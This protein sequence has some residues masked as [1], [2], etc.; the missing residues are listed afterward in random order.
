METFYNIC[1]LYAKTA[2]PNI[3]PIIEWLDSFDVFPI[4]EIIP[5]IQD[6]I[7]SNFVTSKN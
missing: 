5:E 4:T 2:D 6:L 1:W 3:P 7:M